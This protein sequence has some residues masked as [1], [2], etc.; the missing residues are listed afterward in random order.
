[1]NKKYLSVILFSRQERSHLVRTTMM[2]S[3]TYKNRWT[4]LSQTLM[5]C[6]KLQ[7]AM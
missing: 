3:T 6:R 4:R 7:V 5:L 2:T 1:M